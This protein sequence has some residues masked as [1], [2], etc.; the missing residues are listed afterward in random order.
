MSLRLEVAQYQRGRQFCSGVLIDILDYVYSNCTDTIISHIFLLHW[1][2]QAEAHNITINE[3][4]GRQVVTVNQ[5][6]KDAL[7]IALPRHLEQRD[8]GHVN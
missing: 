6:N 4:L 5:A 3:Q 1:L 7:M 8:I 2:F